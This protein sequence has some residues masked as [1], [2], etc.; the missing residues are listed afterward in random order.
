[1]KPTEVL[2]NEHRVIERMLSVLE[3]AMER[4]LNVEDLE[5]MIDF[6][7][8]F[9]DKCH[10]GKE[11]DMLFPEMEKAGVPREVGPIGVM[12]MEHTQGRNFIKGMVEAISEIRDGRDSRDKFIENAKNYISL[13]REHIQKE[14]NILFNIAEV[15]LDEKT[16]KNLSE[17]FE[18]FERE[19][20]GEGVHERYHK[21]VEE[22]EKIYT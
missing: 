3:R 2:K 9:A 11:E 7:K 14:D 18:K 16:Q 15:H 1:M 8:N 19:R 10:H 20:I 5:R 13:L 17:R 21:L 6:F 12:L 4:E 22:L